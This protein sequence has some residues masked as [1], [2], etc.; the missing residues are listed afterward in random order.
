MFRIPVGAVSTLLFGILIF[1]ASTA[2]A[3][4][5]QEII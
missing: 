5:P 3:G 1:G 2:T 4:E